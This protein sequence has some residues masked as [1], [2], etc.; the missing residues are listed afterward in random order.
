MVKQ[1]KPR[2]AMTDCVMTDCVGGA[3][4][5][6]GERPFER[7]G[8]S[9]TY[10]LGLWSFLP[11]SAVSETSSSAYHFLSGSERGGGLGELPSLLESSL[12]K[13]RKWALETKLRSPRQPTP[14]GNPGGQ[15]VSPP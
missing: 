10:P 15:F 13:R 8:P 2:P 3:G 11:D 9:P 1:Q 4:S 12:C 6:M 14:S 5:Q 7:P